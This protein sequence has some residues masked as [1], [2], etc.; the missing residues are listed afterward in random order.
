MV[1]KYWFVNII[2]K[3]LLTVYTFWVSLKIH[4]I[5]FIEN[6]IQA[7]LISFQTSLGDM[8]LNQSRLRA[9]KAQNSCLVL[10]AIES[11]KSHVLYTLHRNLYGSV[12]EKMSLRYIYIKVIKIIH[13]WIAITSER[14]TPLTSYFHHFILHHFSMVKY[15]LGSCTCSV[16]VLQ[17]PIPHRV[18][19]RHNFRQE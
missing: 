2:W 7:P 16:L 11:L 3:N 12:S 9:V 6:V 14:Y 19:T 8:G 5:E 4:V 13:V 10:K 18:W 1:V 15:F 17:R